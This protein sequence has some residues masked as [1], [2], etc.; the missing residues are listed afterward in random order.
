MSITMV[1][2]CT[3]DLPLPGELVAVMGPSGC[4]KTTLLDVLG[5]RIS[6]GKVDG[7]V[8]IGAKKRDPQYARQMVNYVSQEDALLTC[9]T[10]RWS[11]RDGLLEWFS[12]SVNAAQV[13]AVMF[14]F[15]VLA[16]H[17]TIL[18]SSP[19]LYRSP[20]EEGARPAAVPETLASRFMRHGRTCGAATSPQAL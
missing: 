7:T 1:P 16:Q 19:R 18:R 9:F 8:E 6:K 13:I 14:P 20:A 4:G 5:D 10:V 15:P 17:D 11:A 2:G 3:S 12:A